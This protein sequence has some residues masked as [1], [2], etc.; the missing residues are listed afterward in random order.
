VGGDF[1][2][3][4][5]FTKKTRYRSKLTC[6]EGRLHLD[7]KLRARRMENDQTKPEPY[8]L[9]RRDLEKSWESLGIGPDLGTTI[10]PSL[11]RVHATR[12]ESSSSFPRR[13]NNEVL[14]AD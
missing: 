11:S 7:E 5:K 8:S 6:I 2:Y 4:S 10:S 14:A 3:V 9:N 12:E 1:K 13:P